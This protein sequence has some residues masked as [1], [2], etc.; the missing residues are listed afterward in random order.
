MCNRGGYPD[1][2]EVNSVQPRHLLH[3]KEPTVAAILRFHRPFC[4]S[5]ELRDDASGI[6]PMRQSEQDASGNLDYASLV[7]FH[8]GTMRRSIKDEITHLPIS[9]QRKYQLRMQRDKKCTE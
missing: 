8:S 3:A 2:S 5:G 7:Q 6:H 9:R 1:E 4:K